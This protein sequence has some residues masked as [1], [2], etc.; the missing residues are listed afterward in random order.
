ML[1]MY[2]RVTNERSKRLAKLN[3][4]EAHVLRLPV[5]RLRAAPGLINADMLV[6]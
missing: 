5:A 2:M 6:R 3:Q 1:N 4:L